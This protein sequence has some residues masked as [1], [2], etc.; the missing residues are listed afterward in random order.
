MAHT[1]SSTLL[2]YW[3]PGKGLTSLEKV[4]RTGGRAS[5]EP[6]L[7]LAGSAA[8]VSHFLCKPQF[9]RL[10]SGTNTYLARFLGELNEMMYRQEY[11]KK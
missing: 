6:D 9:P 1:A 8:L 7:Q 11:H 2:S 4:Q 3:H 5:G 10:Y